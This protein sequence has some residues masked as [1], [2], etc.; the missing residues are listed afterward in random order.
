M[1]TM[2]YTSGIRITL[3]KMMKPQSI[4]FIRKGA[5]G[6]FLIQ[7]YLAKCDGI[8]YYRSEWKSTA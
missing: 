4:P 1:Y 2:R 8:A 7:K 3:G 6:N 5:L